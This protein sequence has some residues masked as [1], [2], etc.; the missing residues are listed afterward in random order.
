MNNEIT[1]KKMLSKSDAAEENLLIGKCNSDPIPWSRFKLGSDGLLPCIVQDV[2][3]GE[4]LMM[5]YM[6]Q[7]SYEHTC[8][9][10]RMT[11]YSRSRQCLWIKGDTSGHYQYVQ[12]LSADCDW[13]TLLAKVEQVG[14]ACHTG[15]YSCFFRTITD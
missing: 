6:N 13:D 9:T 12:S 8:R 15:S 7:E 1:T 11:Y 5:A 2:R 3:T 14:A 4:V 10:G